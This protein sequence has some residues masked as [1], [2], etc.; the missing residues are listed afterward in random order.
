MPN[1]FR[2]LEFPL[3]RLSLDCASDTPSPS[4]KRMLPSILFWLERKSWIPVSAPAG[5]LWETTLS[6]SVTSWDSTSRIPK[7]GCGTA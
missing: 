2:E 3:T 5:S 6:R 1:P 4:A 7:R